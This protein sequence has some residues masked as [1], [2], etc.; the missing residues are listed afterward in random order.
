MLRWLA[1]TMR[2]VGWL[3]TTSSWLMPLAKYTAVSVN[4]VH[5]NL[6]SCMAFLV[7]VNK[8]DKTL[9]IYRSMLESTDRR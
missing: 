4:G 5:L 9:V 6:K 3:F 8:K 2:L 1:M 7:E